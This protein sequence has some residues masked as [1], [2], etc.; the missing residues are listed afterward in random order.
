MIPMILLGIE[1]IPFYRIRNYRKYVKNPN[2]SEY[3]LVQI[4]GYQIGNL[5]FM[6]GSIAVL[7]DKRQALFP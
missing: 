1:Y 3:L 5:A 6:Y 4:Y 2:N 7:I